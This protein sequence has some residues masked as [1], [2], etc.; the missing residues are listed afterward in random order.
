M[1]PTSKHQFR[2]FVPLS[3]LSQD[4]FNEI[5]N[6]IFIEKLPAD[7]KLFEQGKSRYS[8]YYLLSGELEIIEGNGNKTQLLSNTEQSRFPLVEGGKSD[9]KSFISKTEI[10]YFKIDNNLLDILLT[11]EQNKSYIVNEIGENDADE[12]SNDWMTQLLQLELFHKIPPANIQA[13]FQKIEPVQ[14]K[15][16]DVIIKQEEKGDYYYI[17]QS[18]TCRVLRKG[19]ETGFKEIVIANLEAGSGFGEDALVTNAVRNATIIMNT[20]GCLMRLAKN[21]FLEL[22]KEPIIK[23]VS[24]NRAQEMIK[25]GAVWIDVRSISEHKNNSIPGS[26]NIPLYLLRLNANKLSEQRKYIIYCDTGSRSASAT[27]ILNEKGYDAYLLDGGLAQSNDN[28][29]ENNAA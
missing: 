25:E 28:S 6:K 21:D 10:E 1:K 9:K 27:Y 15:K 22:L 26:L 4:N 7:T 18:G 8:N 24:F 5:T 20:D 23:S 19:R 17:I 29:K 3:E 13:M 14:V 12:D 11:W 2:H 16:D